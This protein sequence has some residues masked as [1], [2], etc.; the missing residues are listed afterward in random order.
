MLKTVDKVWGSELWI[1]NNELYCGKIL[2]IKKDFSTSIHYHKLK[3][4][5]FFLLEGE[6]NV[7]LLGEVRTLRKGE[8]LRLKPYTIHRITG[9]Q[10]S[11]KLLEISTHH[12]D[13]DSIRLKIL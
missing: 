6:I 12:Q 7:E 1:V 2:N 4:E 5:T 3:D 11:N 9:L 10:E 13:S 8:T